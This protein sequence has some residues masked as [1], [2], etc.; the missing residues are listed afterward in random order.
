M[1][2]TKSTDGASGAT[3]EGPRP[4]RRW[5]EPLFA[6]QERRREVMDIPLRLRRNTALYGLGAVACRD[7]RR[8]P[9]EGRRGPKTFGRWERPTS[10][11]TGLRGRRCEGN[12]L[13]RDRRRPHCV[14]RFAVAKREAQGAVAH[15]ARCLRRAA[16]R[17]AARRDRDRRCPCRLE[18]ALAIAPGD[19]VAAG[20][21]IEMVL[22]AARALGHIDED[23][24]NVARWRGHLDRLL[25]KRTRLSRGHHAA[26][27]Y[28]EVPGF[29]DK[30]R[31]IDTTGARAIELIVLT[32]AR[33]GEVLSMKKDEVDQHAAVWTVPAPKIKAG[34]PHRVPLVDRALQ[35]IRECAA[36]SD[37][38]FIFPGQRPGRPLSNRA[39]ELT[40]KK[41]TAD[42]TLHGFRSSFRDWVG[43][44]TRYPRELADS[45]LAHAVGDQTE[46]A[47][48]RSDAL[49][50]RR[51]MMIAWANFIDRTGG[52]VLQFPQESSLKSQLGTTDG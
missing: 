8:G 35:I 37:D 2:N 9:R 24:A 12:D 30:L 49:E 43:D 13:R 47:Y 25:A 42:A 18:A 51:E 22:D 32:A 23:R 10:G 17:H 5:R 46:A 27:P 28:A 48:R 36:T 39:V 20:G 34:R 15:D 11:S 33:L 52:D 3:A 21:R 38:D 26:M 7:P 29:V 50:R 44:A 16:A 14:Q 41:L 40:M 1:R 45:A 4:A 6:D 31:A 19:S